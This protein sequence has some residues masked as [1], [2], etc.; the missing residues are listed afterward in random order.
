M[1]GSAI[2]GCVLIAVSGA[3]GLWACATLRDG[4]TTIMPNRCTTHLVTNGPYRF[5]RNPIYLS[6]SFLTLGFGLV[7]QNSWFF[8]LTPIVGVLTYSVV[9]RAEEL[10]LL[11]RFGFDFE[12]YRRKTRC[13]I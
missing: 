3:I 10:H 12:H 7:T 8:I 13:W 4:H 2:I 5:S 6:Y 1:W 11:A 9:I